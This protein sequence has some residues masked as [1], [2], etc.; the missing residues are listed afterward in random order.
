MKV[1]NTSV[2]VSIGFAVIVA[3]NTFSWPWKRYQFPGMPVPPH[4][5]EAEVNKT[6]ATTFYGKNPFYSVTWCGWWD[7]PTGTREDKLCCH[8]WDCVFL[9][10]VPLWQQL[11]AGISNRLRGRSRYCSYLTKSVLPS[12]LLP[13][14]L[15]LLICAALAGTLSG[16]KTAQRSEMSG[17]SEQWST[18]VRRFRGQG[19]EGVSLN[20]KFS[21]RKCCGF[22]NMPSL[23]PC[24][25][26][27]PI[28]SQFRSPANFEADR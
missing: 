7:R 16:N 6:A 14:S 1:S 25:F 27:A 19:P 8:K 9:S 13:S 12:L 4:A 28:W 18:A 11:M 22:L 26:H 17:K 5:M 20:G 10:L 2:A 3:T 15:L 24:R 21:R 23:V